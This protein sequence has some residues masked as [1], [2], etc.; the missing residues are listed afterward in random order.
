MTRLGIFIGTIL[1][2]AV[3]ACGAQAADPV[4]GKAS[5]TTVASTPKTCTGVW[6]FIETNC[7]LPGSGIRL[8]G[9]ID[10]GYGYQTHGA[11]LDPRSPPGASYLVQKTN[12]GPRWELAPNGLSN[13]LV[14]IKGTEPIGWNTS[15]VFALDAGFD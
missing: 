4:P 12:R 5:P 11:P 14:G 10:A 1:A 2:A 7:Q 3:A 15:V 9:A 13:S 8:Y 6:D